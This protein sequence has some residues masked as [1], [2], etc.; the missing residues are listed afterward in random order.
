MRKILVL[1]AVVLVSGIVSAQNMFTNGDFET[2]SLAPWTITATSSN[3]MTEEQGVVLFDID[4]ADPLPESLG[5]RFEVG[6]V[7]AQRGFFEG[8]EMTQ[9]LNLTAGLEYAFYFDWAASYTGGGNFGD[10][11]FFDLIVDGVVLDSGVAGNCGPAFPTSFGS[12]SANFTPTTTGVHTVGVRITRNGET[13]FAEIYQH[14]DNASAIGPE[15]TVVP[16]S[17]TL[18]RGVLTGGGLSD[19]LAS[20]D[21]WMTVLPGITLNQAERQ[22]QLVI[23]G[24]SPTETPSEL[25]IR[26]EAHA[27][28]NNIGQWIELWNYDTNSYEQ[29]DFMI[30]TTVDSIVEVSITV[31]PGR[32]IQAGTKKMRAKVSYKEAG[33]VLFFPWLISFDQTVWVIVP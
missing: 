29:V 32:F 12:L 30:A 5:A 4:F 19:L 6:Q 24:T 25:R 10:C 18:F 8:I 31:D 15:E 11:G 3:G 1:I 13:G 7:E 21:S 23:E 2:G 33:I 20:D 26:V 28:I 14:I 17:F 22:V 16:D 27:E 9:D